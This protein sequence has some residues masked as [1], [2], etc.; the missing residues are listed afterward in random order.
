MKTVS[1]LVAAVCFQ[2]AL[3]FFFFLLFAV[4]LY[5]QVEVD[6]WCVVL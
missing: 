6:V 1:L 5:L 3:C 2:F 4:L